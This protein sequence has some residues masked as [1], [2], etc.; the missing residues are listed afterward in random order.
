VDSTNYNV[1]AHINRTPHEIVNIDYDRAIFMGKGAELVEYHKKRI[2]MA[3]SPAEKAKAIKDTEKL[4]SAL[5]KNNTLTTLGKG[6]VMPVIIYPIFSIVMAASA[7]ALVFGA[8]VVAAGSVLTLVATPFM[9]AKGIYNSFEAN[10]ARKQH[11]YEL[12]KLIK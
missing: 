5:E 1:T 8:A 6:A 9:S 4:I 11:I 7:V 10:Q 3:R 12:K 2:A